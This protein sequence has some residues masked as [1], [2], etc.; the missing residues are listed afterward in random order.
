MMQQSGSQSSSSSSSMSK[1]E[2]SSS[3]AESSFEQSAEQQALAAGHVAGGRKES[4]AAGASNANA[5]QGSHY[6]THF[7]IFETFF[8]K[9]EIIGIIC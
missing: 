5:N 1:S 9:V 3:A 7:E 2:Q 6:F 4:H 8:S